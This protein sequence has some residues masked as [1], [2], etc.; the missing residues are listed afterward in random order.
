MDIHDFALGVEALAEECYGSSYSQE[1]S[2]HSLLVEKIYYNLCQYDEFQ[3]IL[4]SK[5]FKN[6]FNVSYVNSPFED[7][8][9]NYQACREK[10]QLKNEQYQQKKREFQE[11]KLI[12][13]G[14]FEIRKTQPKEEEVVERKE[15]CKRMVYNKYQALKTCCDEEK[16]ES[17]IR[18]RKPKP[19]DFLAPDVCRIL[20]RKE[21]DWKLLNKEQ[22]YVFRP[23]FNNFLVA[24]FKLADLYTYIE[25]TLFNFSI[26]W[27][28]LREFTILL[29]DYRVQLYIAFA[30]VG[31]C[32]VFGVKGI[33]YI[34]E[35][36]LGLTETRIPA[37]FPHPM[38]FFTVLYKLL[39]LASFNTIVMTL[40]STFAC[41]WTTAAVE[42]S[43]F[44]TLSN[45]N[46][47][48]TCFSTEHSFYLVFSLICLLIYYPLST[49]TMPNFQFAEKRLDLKFKPSYLIIYFQVNF[50]M[51]AGKVILYEIGKEDSTINILFISICI[52]CLVILGL[53]VL[54]MRPCLI[55]WFNLVELLVI[56]I[57]LI[58]NVMGFVLFFFPDLVI[59]CYSVA[60]GVTLL[61]IIICII[62]IRARYFSSNKVNVEIENDDIEE[63]EQ[64]WEYKKEVG[65]NIVKFDMDNSE[66]EVKSRSDKKHE[67]IAME[68]ITSN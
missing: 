57:G 6:K 40:F 16:E 63:L 60:G 22:D 66:K 5:A 43:N 52:G 65:L 34:L 13:P 25:I 41:N 30:L 11:H 18:K 14:E 45:S 54:F 37:Q 46:N 1:K 10:F 49:Y 38:F 3:D 68:E 31:I 47:L 2:S 32:L 51:A 7:S 55:Y 24:A 61:S 27:Q 28:N 17:S 59:L 53:C 48:L 23:I 19:W 36:R 26:N 20:E 35:D 33:Q 58:W 50:V 15:S 56:W 4:H 67:T 8:Y 44:V 21:S 42:G 29:F 39:V 64:G 9:S 62:T 12:E